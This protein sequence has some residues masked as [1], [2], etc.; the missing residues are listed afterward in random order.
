MTK[1]LNWRIFLVVATTLFAAYLLFPT[2]IKFKTGKPIPRVKQAEDPWYYSLF[3]SEVLRL[4]L[5][6][7]GGVHLV[8]GID[9]EE[10]QKSAIQKLQS[11]L[12]EIIAQ[13]KIEGV[14]T[15]L[16]QDTYIKISY[17]SD[18][19]W[20]KIDQIIGRQ[21]GQTIDF[22]GQSEKEATLR[23]SALYMNEV[24]ARAIDQSLETLRNRID[25]FGIAEPIIQRHGDDR[26]LVQFPGVREIGRLKD[27]ISRTARLSFQMEISGP[28]VPG[29]QPTFQEL[30]GL[31]A[32]FVKDKKLKF[33]PTDSIAQHLN[34]LN[35]YL[36]EGKKIPA[37]SE[38]RFKKEE[39]INTKEVSYTPYLLEKKPILTG[40]E[41]DD[42]Y[43]GFNQKNEA[44]VNFSVS[45]GAANKFGEGTGANI[46]HFMAIVL[47]NNVH[48][49]PRINARITD[50]GL[51][52]MGGGGSRNPQQVTNDA[53]DTALVLRS[54]ALP[55]RLQ[56]L[57]E[58]VIGP[59]LGADAI[60]SGLTAL[61]I[62]FMAVL[63]FIIIYYR[64][65]GIVAVGALSLNGI[66]VL[67][68]MAA[69]E[70]TLSL[71]GLAGLVLTLGMAVDANVIIFEYIRE[72]LRAGKGV[73][74]AIAEGYGRAWSA[75]LDG[76]LTTIIA[77]VILL[78]FGYGPIRGFAVTLLIGII[79]SMFTAVFVTRVFFDYFVVAKGRQSINI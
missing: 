69:F 47:D 2:V 72:E 42:A 16:S 35:R 9:F 11:Q 64:V 55:A 58:R 53:K 20:E 54:G 74:L 56:F 10:V 31:V 73:S 24:R 38:V 21:F 46:G 19:A 50:R 33:G 13:E 66:F 41:L 57:E 70:A 52:E 25:E 17:P 34:D 12:E 15:S 37:D 28:E 45:P 68:I 61:I 59:S 43:Y 1:R 14:T 18:A 30:Q 8:L 67:G 65:A 75:I 51:I 26:I 77:A 5:D 29:G 7:R 23:M 49:A 48:S 3:P 78:S 40:D 4:G 32:S 36:E 22:E 76:N 44:V 60:R 39:D 62:G 63:V 79:C 71:P 27:I 6:L